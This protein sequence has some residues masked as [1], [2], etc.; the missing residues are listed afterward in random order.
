MSDPNAR[1]GAPA[2]GDLGSWC[3]KDVD[4]FE[5]ARR[6]VNAVIAAYSTR[7]AAGPDAAAD[8]RTE[9]ARYATVLRD[10]DPTDQVNLARIVRE[11]PVLI[12]RVR[13][14]PGA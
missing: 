3:E 7:I 6:L 11:Y 5:L 14:E 9:Q 10:L 12:R 13:G 2:G 4:R 8:L 1:N